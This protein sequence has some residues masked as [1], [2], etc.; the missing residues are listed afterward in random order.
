MA[1]ET[2]PPLPPRV[3]VANLDPATPGDRAGVI[4]VGSPFAIDPAEA[5][6]RYPVS[7]P[8]AGGLSLYDLGPIRYTAMGSVAAAALVTGFA[9]AAAW[10]FPTGGLLVTALGCGLALFGLVSA[11]RLT[12]LLLLLIHLSLFVLS[13]VRSIS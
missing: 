3:P 10:W 12:S 2:G 4:R 1:A 11:Y 13:F 9:A 8:S 6:G 5:A 7:A